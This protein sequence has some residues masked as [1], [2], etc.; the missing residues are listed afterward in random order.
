MCFKLV[1]NAKQSEY[2]R[3]ITLCSTVASVVVWAT[4]Y[5][6]AHCNMMSGC[7]LVISTFPA[8][9]T[10]TK[11]ASFKWMGI[12]CVFSP[13]R[14]IQHESTRCVTSCFVC[15]C[16][17]FLLARLLDVTLGA[18]LNPQLHHCFQRLRSLRLFHQ[19]PTYNRDRV[20]IYIIVTKIA[21]KPLSLDLSI[22][23]KSLL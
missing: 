22:C 20:S 13:Q 6:I 12:T 1:H 7:W 17:F 9:A 5:L 18:R 19:Y 15:F 4:A 2:T 14:Q 10:A 11:T 23:P 8:H 16:F 21:T 3:H